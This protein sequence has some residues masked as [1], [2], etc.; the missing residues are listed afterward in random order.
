M[1][2]LSLIQ[3]LYLVGARDRVDIS[4]FETMR[5]ISTDLEIETLI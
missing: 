3:T 4:Y 1:F 2:I 5:L